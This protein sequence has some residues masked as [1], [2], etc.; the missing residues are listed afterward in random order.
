MSCIDLNAQLS[1][2]N[3]MAHCIRFNSATVHCI[4]SKPQP[5]HQEHPHVHLLST[6]C[7][8]FDKTKVEGLASSPF[9]I[10]CDGNTSEVQ[11]SLRKIF[12][13]AETCW[14]NSVFG[15]WWQL[16][17]ILR[18]RADLWDIHPLTCQ[19]ALSLFESALIDACCKYC[20]RP[21]HD[22]LQSNHFGI[23]FTRIRP[24]LSHKQPSDFLPAPARS[25][26]L[27]I[28]INCM[29]ETCERA[30][31]LNRTVDHFKIVLSGVPEEDYATLRSL[32][33]DI[34]EAKG[35][36]FRFSIDGNRAFSTA[37]DFKTLWD[38][39][40]EDPGLT[41]FCKNLLHVEEPFRPEITFDKEVLALFSE[42]PRRPPIL[43]NHSD[44]S[45]HSLPQAIE[46]GYAGTT[47]SKLKGIFKGIANRCWLIACKEREPIGKY[48]MG[49]EH[50]SPVDPIGWG[51]DLAVQ[52]SLGFTH[53]STQTQ[54][55]QHP[56]LQ[57]LWAGDSAPV[58]PDTSSPEWPFSASLVRGC[59]ATE[60]LLQLLF[61]H[62]IET[63]PF[64]NT[65][66][67][68]S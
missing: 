54:C 18:D 33:T 50:L 24:E 19:V 34:Q 51:Q 56:G 1:E 67:L 21:F 66:L 61:G 48:T 22:L 36:Q 37:R 28:P 27:R 41:E 47:H 11:T 46:H 20:Q 14:G 25:I 10:P 45:L 16:Q 52:A 26:H 49:G 15:L 60:P 29:D 64:D 40:Q 32:A 57:I 42:W 62:A 4:Q 59:V 3:A 2:R 5:V 39:C 65:T 31:L 58:G 38:L 63:L 43:L 53:V 9:E 68:H 6:L 35:R 13:V 12:D 23:D 55:L 44:T 30:V 8:T 17:A 7:F